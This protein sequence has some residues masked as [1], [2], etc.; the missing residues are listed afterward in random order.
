M[1]V[2]VAQLKSRFRERPLA[3]SRG[4]W[5]TCGIYAAQPISWASTSHLRGVGVSAGLPLGLPEVWAGAV[6]R[7]SR[8]STTRA[9]P[10]EAQS[11]PRRAPGF[12]LPDGP[13]S[14]GLC[15]PPVPL[16]GYAVRGRGNAK[17]ARP[18]RPGPAPSAK[19]YTVSGARGS[20]A[21]Q[22]RST[23]S[24][25]MRQYCSG[26]RRA[27]RASMPVIPPSASSAAL[28][29]EAAASGE[30][31]PCST[32]MSARALRSAVIVIVCHLM[33]NALARGCLKINGL[34]ESY[35]NVSCS[36]SMS[37]SARAMVLI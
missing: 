18:E 15:R 23:H 36:W 35:G 8:W 37:I 11:E 12:T 24:P 32:Q 2:G 27:R 22:G 4:T 28:K 1:P 29:M 30:M 20:S 26:E 14:G 10:I 34:R 7:R 21:R 17:G 33:Q 19:R 6:L 3:V 13:Q 9:A 31:V 25:H 16:H 5:A